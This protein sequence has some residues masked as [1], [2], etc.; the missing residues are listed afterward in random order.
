[1]TWLGVGFSEAR[2]VILCLIL[3]P[4][5]QYSFIYTFPFC[6]PKPCYQSPVFLIIIVTTLSLPSSC[7]SFYIQSVVLVCM[8]GWGNAYVFARL[9]FD[10]DNDNYVIR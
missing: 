7:S 8:V 3:D 6:L 4:E 2:A 10:Y 9:Y 5:F 1:M